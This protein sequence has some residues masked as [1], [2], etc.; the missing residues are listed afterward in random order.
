MKIFLATHAHNVFKVFQLVFDIM[1]LTQAKIDENQ[2]FAFNL[3]QH[4]GGHLRKPRV[5]SPLRSLRKE[6]SGLSTLGLRR[7]VEGRPLQH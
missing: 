1:L 5:L 6:R 4:C 3:P 7:C 2:I